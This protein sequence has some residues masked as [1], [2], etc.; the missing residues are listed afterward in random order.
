[1]DLRDSAEVNY[2]VEK[3]WWLFLQRQYKDL[4][5]S[6]LEN[7]K[8]FQFGKQSASPMQLPLAQTVYI[9]TVPVLRTALGQLLDEKKPPQDEGGISIHFN[10][11]FDRVLSL[12][13]QNLFKLTAHEISSVLRLCLYAM[14]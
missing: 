2:V 12:L 7:V 1:M 8:W 6:P 3:L 10:T 9:E 5:M 11:F 4:T 13:G 14:A